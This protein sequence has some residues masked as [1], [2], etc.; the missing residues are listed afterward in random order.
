M[1]KEYLIILKSMQK[2]REKEE[3][4]RPEVHILNLSLTTKKIPERL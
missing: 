1:P 3:R 4:E 2:R